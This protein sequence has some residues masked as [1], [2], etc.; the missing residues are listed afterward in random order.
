M[1]TSD[2]FINQAID[3][4]NESHGAKARLDLLAQMRPLAKDDAARDWVTYFEDWESYAQG[5][6]ES[7][8]A[9]QKSQSAL[10]AGDLDLARR[11]IAAAKPEIVIDQYSKTIRHGNISPSEK[12]ILI[13]LNLR[14]LPHIEAQRQAVG[15]EPLQVEFAPTNHE[16]LAQGAGHYSFDFDA[17]KKVI[18]VLGS[19][20]LGVDVQQ[21]EAGAKCSTGIEV[22]SPV[23]LAIGGL[24]GA[25]LSP[26]TYRMKLNI[27]DGAQVDVESGVSR[28]AITSASEINVRSSRRKGSLHTLASLRNNSR[29][30]ADSQFATF[31]AVIRESCFNATLRGCR[32]SRRRPLRA[33]L[34][35]GPCVPLSLCV[36]C[37]TLQL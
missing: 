8:T 20:E 22:R 10:K 35:P 3:L 31:S 15:L 37:R 26:G 32:T 2:T 9:M 33:S 1:E 17:S 23:K 24:A 27:P 16:P 4:E 34:L 36:P 19:A 21:F 12:G 5:F 28:Q 13:T 29:M 18:E 6:Y 30:R 25:Q 11:E 14:W 7:Q